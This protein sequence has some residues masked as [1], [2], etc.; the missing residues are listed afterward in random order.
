MAREKNF[1]V[2]RISE[3]IYE[4]TKQKSV[5]I[6][7]SHSL[8]FS[9]VLQSIPRHLFRPDQSASHEHWPDLPILLKV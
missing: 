1:E 2:I 7:S 4:C 9:L 5:K 6:I 8:R 3:K